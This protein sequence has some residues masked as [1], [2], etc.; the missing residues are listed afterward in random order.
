MICKICNKHVKNFIGLANH[1]RYKHKEIGNQGYYDL[2]LKIDQNEGI[3]KNPNCSNNT[4][5]CGLNEG[6]AKHCS[7]RCKCLDPVVKEKM[8]K[9]LFKNHGV[10]HALQSKTIFQKMEDDNFKKYGK[11]NVH[12]I[13]EFIEKTADTCL[14]IY[15]VS[16]AL[17]TEKARNNNPEI[18]KNKFVSNETIEKLRISNTGVKR[19]E[20][21][22][23]KRRLYM[24]S[25]GHAQYVSSFAGKGENHPHWNPNRE[26]VYRPYTEKFHSKVFRKEIFEQQNYICPICGKNL[27]NELKHLHHIDYNKQNDDRENLIFLCKNCHPKTN[28]NRNKWYLELKII[29]ENLIKRRIIECE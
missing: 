5:Y 8:E 12:Q 25:D 16:C 14:K 1:I 23:D 3:C 17:L 26:E 24:L 15:G 19:S 29:N 7:G 28:Y 2:F 9:T 20:E 10:K 22:K 21:F 27:K 11:K 18:R 6:Y 4:T 13:K